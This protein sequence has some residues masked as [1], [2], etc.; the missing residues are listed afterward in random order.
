MIRNLAKAVVLKQVW[1]P[2]PL[3]RWHWPYLEAFVC[4]KWG[5]GCSQHLVDR[6]Q[7]CCYTAYNSQDGGSQQIIPPNTPM[8]LRLKKPWYESLETVPDVN[9]FF[10]K[11]LNRDPWVAQRFSAYVQ[12][13]AWSWRPRIES[14]IGLPAWSL[15]LPLPVSLPLSVCVSHE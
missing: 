2:C 4:H 15:L 6:C 1:F 7:G 8:Q 11:A 5:E 10:K 9:I 3:P 14:H 13:R 12:P